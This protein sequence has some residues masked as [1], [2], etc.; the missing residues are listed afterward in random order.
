MLSRLVFRHFDTT[1]NPFG[2]WLEEATHGDIGNYLKTRGATVTKHQRA[3]WC[4]QVAEAVEYLH[5]KKVIHRDL[6][7]ENLLLNRNLDLMLCDFGGSQYSSFNGLGL[8]NAGFFQ[9]LVT[10]VSELTDIFALGST[11]YTIMTGQLPHQE[12]VRDA[13]DYDAIVDVRFRNGKFPDVSNIEGGQTILECWLGQQNDVR[14]IKARL[15]T[16]LRA[17]GLLKI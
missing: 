15:E 9:P 13:E 16:E 1:E 12:L 8:P 6:R 2:I 4:F 14:N 11:M 10:E 17:S 7:P 5:S 3:K